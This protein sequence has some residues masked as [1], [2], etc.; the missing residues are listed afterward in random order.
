MA[1]SQG[2]VVEQNAREV[3]LGQET[4]SDGARRIQV[5]QFPETMV[6]CKVV[7]GLIL[8]LCVVDSILEVDIRVQMRVS[9]RGC[10]C[11]G[12]VAFEALWRERGRNGVW[13]SRETSWLFVGWEG[14]CRHGREGFA[15]RPEGGVVWF[16]DVHRG[17]HAGQSHGDAGGVVAVDGSHG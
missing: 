13:G 16:G 14:L 4:R 6:P 2:A 7:L 9:W 3:V 1:D 5:C 12:G 17:G 15:S 10:R 11:N 8:R